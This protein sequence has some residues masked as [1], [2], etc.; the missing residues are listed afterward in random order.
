MG[1]KRLLAFRLISASHLNSASDPGTSFWSH[2]TGFLVALSPCI[3][4]LLQIMNIA[5]GGRSLQLKSTTLSDSH[6]FSAILLR[7]LPK[8]IACNLTLKSIRKLVSATQVREA[9]WNTATKNCALY[10]E[11]RFLVQCHRKLW[12]RK[13]VFLTGFALR[14]LE[15]QRVFRTE[16]AK[17]QQNVSR[18]ASILTGFGKF[19]PV[20]QLYRSVFFCLW[21]GINEIYG[22]SSLIKVLWLEM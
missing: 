16:L 7:N 14:N 2:W 13:T 19:Q 12:K 15:L 4:L 17:M 5:S 18:L 6:W 21:P 20:F 11:R 3:S 9:K 1:C 22:F 8:K 10:N